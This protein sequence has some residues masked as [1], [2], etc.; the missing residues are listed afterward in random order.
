MFGTPYAKLGNKIALTAWTGDPATYYRNGDY[1]T[2]HIA[3][4]P[5]FDEDGLHG[6][7]GCLPGQGAGGHS[8]VEQHPGLRPRLDPAGRLSRRGTRRA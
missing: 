3:I 7:P 4:C 2:G 1:G 6:V 5:K 8:R